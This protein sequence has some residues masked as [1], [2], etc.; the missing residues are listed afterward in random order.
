[1]WNI[2]GYMTFGIWSEISREVRRAGTGDEAWSR[3]L[4]AELLPGTPRGHETILLS[5]RVNISTIKM[6]NILPEEM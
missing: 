4:P 2:S 6:F 1:M 3:L 5:I